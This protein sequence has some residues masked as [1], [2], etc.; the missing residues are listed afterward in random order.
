[1]VMPNFFK[2][3]QKKEDD[4][5]S[6][7]RDDPRRADCKV[8]IEKLWGEYKLCA[9]RDFLNQAQIAFHQHWWEM[10][11]T[12][13]LLHLFKDSGFKVEK[14]PRSGGPDVKI[15][16][17]DGK[18]IWI[19]A[20][21]PTKGDAKKN[22]KDIVPDPEWTYAKPLPERELLLRFTTGLDAK[23]GKFEG[24]ITKKTINRGDPCVIALSACN[25]D[26]Y[27][28]LLNAPAPALLKVLA[29]VGNMTINKNGVY[30]LIREPLEKKESKNL[31]SVRWFE[32]PSFDS[33]SAVLYSSSDP[34]NAP[35]LPESTFRLFLN[36]Y[37]KSPLPTRFNTHIDTWYREKNGK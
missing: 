18:R 37:A 12:V 22:P 3:P 8:K 34:I 26:M 9:S 20:V 11:L 21:A 25:L 17:A 10:Y 7:L 29:G 4:L 36:P 28:S 15:T 24:Y 35:P 16:Y 19:E 30:F 23:K 32:D 14:P 27:A 33:I 1:M 6:N 2:L 5:Y 31:V 13:G